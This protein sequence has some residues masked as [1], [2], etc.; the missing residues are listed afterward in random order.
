MGH[1]YMYKCDIPGYVFENTMDYKHNTVQKEFYTINQT[2]PQVRN[3]VV[4]FWRFVCLA[5]EWLR[6]YLSVHRSARQMTAS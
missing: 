4:T 1:E 3:T 2:S 6:I 5:H